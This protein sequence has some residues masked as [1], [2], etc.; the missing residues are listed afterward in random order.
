MRKIILNVAVSLD[1]FIED[2]NGAYDWCFMDQDYGLTDFSNSIDTIFFGRK[3]YELIRRENY[4]D[5]YKSYK[6]Y[7]FST[8]LTQ[9]DD[10]TVAI[11]SNDAIT[12]IHKIK[13]EQGKNIWLFGG[14]SLVSFF[15]K[16]NLV[17]EL[18]LSV[19]PILLGSGKSL[20]EN[21][22][23]RKQLKLTNSITY[24]T[25]LVQLFYDVLKAQ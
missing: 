1:L 3:S 21:L 11:I 13:N 12:A 20:F 22:D 15:M 6:Q 5:Y 9:P 8:T 10:K 23:T 17:D 19:H 24:D 25:G 16:E 7:V 18:M 4:T 14:A 2:A